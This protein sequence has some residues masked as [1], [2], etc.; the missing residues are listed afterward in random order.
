MRLGHS[1]QLP[2]SGTSV[3]SF[4]SNGTE[5]SESKMFCSIHAVRSR[6]GSNT[7]V[8]LPPFQTVRNAASNAFSCCACGSLAISSAWPDADLVREKCFRDGRYQF[9]QTLALRHKRRAFARPLRYGCNIVAWRFQPQKRVEC[10]CLFHR[11]HSLALDVLN[12]LCDYTVGI[13]Q[14]DYAHGNVGEFG[15]FRGAKSAGTGNDFVLVI[16]DGAD[17]QGAVRRLAI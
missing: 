11:M 6:N 9:D 14:R 16:A 10:Q 3:A 17:K 13:R 4:L 8:S 1:A 12:Q 2:A 15:Q 7:R 5:S